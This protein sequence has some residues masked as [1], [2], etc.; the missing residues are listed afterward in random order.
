MLIKCSLFK[1][2][3]DSDWVQNLFITNQTIQNQDPNYALF[4]IIKIY[5]LI[6]KQNVYFKYIGRP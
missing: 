6:C 4:L 5:K 3:F 1:R 2:K